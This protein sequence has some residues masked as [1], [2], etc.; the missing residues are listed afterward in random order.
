M[1]SALAPIVDG[2]QAIFGTSTALPGLAPGLIVPDDPA[3]RP[4]LDLGGP[5]LEGLLGAAARHWDAKPPAAAALAWK[6][7]THWVCLPAVLGWLTARRVPALTGTNVRVRLDRPP[8]LPVVGLR[9]G[10]PVFVLPGDPAT[11]GTVVADEGELLA[12]LRRSLLDEHLLPLLG[13]IG[14][15]VRLGPRTLLGSVA[16]TIAA[17]LLRFRGPDPAAEIDFLLAALGLGGLIDL[18]LNDKGICSV[19]R[20]TC[21]LAF[22]LPRPRL[23]RDCV[24]QPAR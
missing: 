4:A 19:R 12:A 2:L 20:R 22:T 8:G 5:L 9:A 7:Y 14:R 3:W 15:R 24:L 1:S 13:T 10:T 17:D 23:C 6:A 21:C 18:S 16:A 11:G